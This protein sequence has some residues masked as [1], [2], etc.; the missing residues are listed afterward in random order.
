MARR[1]RDTEEEHE[2]IE[3]WLV[4]YADF[5]TLLFAFFVVMYSMSSLN[6]GKYKILSQTLSSV[7]SNTQPTQDKKSNNELLDMSTEKGGALVNLLPEVPP[8]PPEP[9]NSEESEKAQLERVAHQME[10][11]LAPYIQDDLVMVKRNEL[12]VEL[13]IKSGLLF[14]SGSAGLAHG[15]EALLYR[16]SQ[17]FTQM[18]NV[19]NVEGHTDNVPISTFE[20]PSNWALSSARA[21]SVVKQLMDYGVSPQRMVALGYGEYHPIADNKQEEGRNRNRRVAIIVMSKQATRYKLTSGIAQENP[22]TKAAESVPKGSG[23]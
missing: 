21:A 11:V 5:I 15:S 3:R 19:I 17:I 2:N 10:A 14:A 1:R 12:W 9:Q 8:G 13:E 18:N 23:R 22:D 6:E 7:F 16:L 4:S 20:F